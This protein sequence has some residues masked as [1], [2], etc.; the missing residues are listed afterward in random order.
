M[1]RLLHLEPAR[2]GCYKN[3]F[4]IS[5]VLFCRLEF[6]AHPRAH[7]RHPGSV[8]GWLV[9]CVPLGVVLSWAAEP[10]MIVCIQDFQF[11]GLSGTVNRR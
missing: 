7:D 2:L 6:L 8:P 11:I 4:A 3:H 10:A 5:P 1:S 9:R